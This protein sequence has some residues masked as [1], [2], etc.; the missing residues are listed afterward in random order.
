MSAYVT[1]LNGS[2]PMGG[3]HPFATLENMTFKHHMSTPIFF[4][5]GNGEIVKSEPF[6]N[7]LSKQTEPQGYFEGR[8]A[9]NPELYIDSDYRNY[10]PPVT[11]TPKKP[12][13]I[14]PE[15]PEVIIPEKPEVIIPEKPEVIIPEKPEVII[16]EKPEVIIPEKPEVVIKP[17]SVIN[18]DTTMVKNVE[19]ATR[20]EDIKSKIS[21]VKSSSYSKGSTCTSCKKDRTKKQHDYKSTSSYISTI[22]EESE[23]ETI[24]DKDEDSSDD[25]S[26]TKKFSIVFVRKLGNGLCYL[27]PDISLDSSMHSKSSVY[28]DDNKIMTID[29]IGNTL[30]DVKDKLILIFGDNFLKYILFSE[31]VTYKLGNRI[32]YFLKLKNGVKINDFNTIKVNECK[33]CSALKTHD[34][35]KV[36][37]YGSKYTPIRFRVADALV[38]YANDC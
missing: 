13:V 17:K 38:A 1:M 9:R 8:C 18:L 34:L 12:E 20:P 36:P 23:Y 35:R 30:D 32:Y 4:P 14:I 16:P 5:V 28:S 31:T 37:I 15:R 29:G 3:I 19:I 33:N 6:R 2:Y 27:L 7:P 24:F 22:T 26:S 21:S 10:R 25:F 11:V